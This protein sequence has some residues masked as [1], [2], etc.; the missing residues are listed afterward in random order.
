MDRIGQAFRAMLHPA[1][2][3]R[4]P[5][6][7]SIAFRRTCRWFI[8]GLAAALFCAAPYAGADGTEQEARLLKAA[9]LYNFAKFTYWPDETWSASRD[10]L[11]LCTMGDDELIE[12]LERLAGKPIKGRTV[13]FRRLADTREL[14]QCHML[15]VAT[16]ESSQV[17][18]IISALIRK[19]LLTVSEVSSFARSGGIIQLYR[20]KERLRFIIN[21]HN[22]REAGL[23]LNARLLN[24]AVVIDNGGTS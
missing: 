18:D 13:R 8:A 22:A 14:T 20:E 9:F 17:A 21:R 7:G 2:A 4:S 10:P 12:V 1:S 11:T 16:S 6:R 23:R 3:A 19:P 5:R 24:L 15:Y